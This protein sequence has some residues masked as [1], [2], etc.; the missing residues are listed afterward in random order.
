[1]PQKCH[2]W[3]LKFLPHPKIAPN[4]YFPIPSRFGKFKQCKWGYITLVL[5]HFDFQSRILEEEKSAGR[6]RKGIFDPYF[7]LWVIL[8][9]ISP[10]K[11]KSKKVINPLRPNEEPVDID[12]LYGQS[13]VCLA[14]HK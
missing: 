12:E 14:C 5:L 7:G 6:P 11:S 13:K 10:E 8:V 4:S 2:F 9:R 3:E 1:M